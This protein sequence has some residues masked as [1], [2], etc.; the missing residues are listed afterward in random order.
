MVLP[1]SHY[2]GHRLCTC[3]PNYTRLSLHKKESFSWMEIGCHFPKHTC[4]GELKSLPSWAMHNYTLLQSRKNKSCSCQKTKQWGHERSKRDSSVFVLFACSAAL[5]LLAVQSLDRLVSLGLLEYPKALELYSNTCWLTTISQH[6]GST[7]HHWL[8]R[9]IS[10][11][12]NWTGA[13]TLP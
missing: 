10:P 9:A 1:W 3:W 6:H 13:S 5:S 4:W 7:Q 2:P 11:L 12:L 8:V